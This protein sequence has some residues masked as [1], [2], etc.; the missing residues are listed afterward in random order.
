MTKHGWLNLLKISIIVGFLT[1]CATPTGPAP[2]SSIS[3]VSKKYNRPIISGSHY[4]VKRGDTLFSIAFSAGISHK[5]L[6]VNNKISKPYTIYPGM[7]LTLS[8][9]KPPIKVVKKIP[10]S[11]KWQKKLDSQ[12]NPRIL[13]LSLSQSAPPRN[14]VVPLN[15]FL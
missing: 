14:H 1:A 7:K 3:A 15:E 10:V 12:K 4:T 5:L 2:V 8:K 13:N 11:K 9:N 6:A